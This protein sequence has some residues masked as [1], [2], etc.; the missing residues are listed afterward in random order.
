M[1]CGT[2][3]LCAVI[4]DDEY[5]ARFGSLREADHQSPGRLRGREVGQRARDY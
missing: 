5:L 4:L 3:P 1:K 2:V